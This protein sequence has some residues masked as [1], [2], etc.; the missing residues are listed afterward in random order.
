LESFL[1]AIMHWKRAPESA[2]SLKRCDRESGVLPLHQP[3]TVCVP[4]C[5]WG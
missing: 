1:C 5:L 3:T 4:A 2:P